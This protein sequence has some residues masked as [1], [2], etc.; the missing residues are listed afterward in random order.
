MTT[1][2]V[3]V[4]VPLVRVS[5]PVALNVIVA[6]ALAATSAPR[7]VHGP[8]P[9]WQVVEELPLSSAVVFTTGPGRASGAA[10]TPPSPTGG[11]GLPG[12]GSP[13][14]WLTLPAGAG[15][16]GRL[17]G[18]AGSSASRSSRAT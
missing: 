9:L 6:P 18:E 2:L 12:P 13:A 16:A 17:H 3:S 5:V 11:G 14:G 7:S 8:L 1:F 4:K 15:T 10:P